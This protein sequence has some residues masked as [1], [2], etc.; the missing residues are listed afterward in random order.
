MDGIFLIRKESIFSSLDLLDNDSCSWSYLLGAIFGP[1]ISGGSATH[2]PY[3]WFF[4]VC[5]IAQGVSRVFSPFHLERFY[6]GN[7]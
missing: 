3:R 1:I 5:T 6:L 2:V 7:F 4:W